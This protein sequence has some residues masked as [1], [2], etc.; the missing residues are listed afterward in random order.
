MICRA[1]LDYEAV[2]ALIRKTMPSAVR[3][4]ATAASG[5]LG[6]GGWLRGKGWRQPA[7]WQQENRRNP[8]AGSLNITRGCGTVATASRLMCHR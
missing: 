5:S 6:E 8:P 7:H 1:Q 4:N 2:L 3:P